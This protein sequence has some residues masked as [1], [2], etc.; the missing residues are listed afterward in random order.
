MTCILF[1]AFFF[2]SFNPKGEE[3]VETRLFISIPVVH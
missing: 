2:T 1:F 3:N